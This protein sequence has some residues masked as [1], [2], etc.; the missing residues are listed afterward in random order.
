MKTI[1]DWIAWGVLVTGS[2]LMLSAVVVVVF[3]VMG[4]IPPLICIATLTAYGWI[5]YRKETQ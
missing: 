5:Q 1:I 2:A 3:A 4:P